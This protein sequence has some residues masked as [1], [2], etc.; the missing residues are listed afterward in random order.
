MNVL[1][2]LAKNWDSVL[3]V[4]VEQRRIVAYQFKLFFNLL[5]NQFM[6]GICHKQPVS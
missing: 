1:T 5:L 4:V 3:V 6:F 2:F